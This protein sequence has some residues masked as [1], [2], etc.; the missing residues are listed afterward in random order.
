MDSEPAIIGTLLEINGEELTPKMA[1]LIEH[2]PDCFNDARAGKVAVAIRKL[3]TEGR[4]VH[5]TS[6]NEWLDFKDSLAYLLG[7]QN[8]SLPIGLAEIEA[9]DLWKNY[10]LRRTAKLFSVAA[11]TMMANPEQ[12]ADIPAG[13]VSELQRID[14][15]C[16]GIRPDDRLFNAANPP[17]EPT[18]VFWI[19]STGICT[20]QNITTVSAQSK[21]GKSA[22]IGAMLAATFAG[23]NADCLGFTSGNPKGLAVI[24]ID[25]EQSPFDH[26]QLIISSI[27]RAGVQS[28]PAWLLPYCLT[29]FKADEIRRSIRPLLQSAKKKFGGVLA[30]LVDGVA[31]AVNDVND[32]AEANAFVAELHALAIEFHCSVIGVIHVNPGGGENWKTRGHLGSQL[33]RKAETNLKCET[34]GHV[35]M[36]SRAFFPRYKPVVRWVLVPLVCLFIV[37]GVVERGRSIGEVGINLYTELSPVT[38][39]GNVIIPDDSR[40][41]KRLALVNSV[42]NICIS[43]ERMFHVQKPIRTGWQKYGLVDFSRKGIIFGDIIG[44]FELAEKCSN[45]YGG[46]FTCILDR[47]NE[48][49]TS[50]SCSSKPCCKQIGYRAGC[51]PRPFVFHSGLFH[52]IQ[53]PLH[54]IQLFIG[55]LTGFNH[56]MPLSA[57]VTGGDNSR[58]ESQKFRKFNN[59]LRYFPFRQLFMILGG[60]SIMVYSVFGRYG[61]RWTWWIFGGGVILYAWGF[62]WLLNWI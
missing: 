59:A 26:H 44:A 56:F 37:A 30:L 10:Q 45:I 22:V 42:I 20:S 55:D 13:V 48:G 32:P 60:V 43:G 6:V 1:R 16:D 57:D 9:A 35:H 8:S 14:S 49:D 52:L 29:G 7:A 18:T 25:T 50:R 27:R 53:L 39:V 61:G 51:N 54:D 2:A 5:Y 21:H 47:Y 36:S 17:A 23:E 38:P 15:E 58:N 41:I 34:R 40:Q 31:D 28:K 4:A 19:G 62:W 11:D 46:C 3:K 24:A 33:E 12:A